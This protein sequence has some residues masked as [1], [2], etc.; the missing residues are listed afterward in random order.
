MR[1]YFFFFL[2]LFTFTCIITFE[3]YK[4][5]KNLQGVHDLATLLQID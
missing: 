5:K 3:Q 1:L 4:M 2:P